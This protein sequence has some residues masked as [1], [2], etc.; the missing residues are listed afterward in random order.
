MCVILNSAELDNK[1]TFDVHMYIESYMH[2]EV[3]EHVDE[4]KEVRVHTVIL[5]Y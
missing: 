1:R 3:Q 4:R 5:Y 2:K